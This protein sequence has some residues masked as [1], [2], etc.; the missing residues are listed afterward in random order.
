MNPAVVRFSV[1]PG[2]VCAFVPSPR[3]Q[4]ARSAACP[5][6]RGGAGVSC[7]YYLFTAAVK[8]ACQRGNLTTPLRADEHGPRAPPICRDTRCSMDGHFAT[9]AR[10]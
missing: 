1:G 9:A 5:I 4:R 6:E 10:L 2:V 3:V 7:R 8:S